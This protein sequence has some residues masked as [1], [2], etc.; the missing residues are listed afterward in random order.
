M[1]GKSRYYSEKSKE[2]K[3]RRSRIRGIAV[4]V[5]ACF[6]VFFAVANIIN[7]VREFSDGENRKLKTVPQLSAES[8]ADGS[9]FEEAFDA[10]SDQFVF[11]DA[12]IGIKSQAELLSG[13][14]KENDTVIGEDGYLFATPETPSASSVSAQLSAVNT[15]AKNNSGLKVSFML[16]P[17]A[18]SVLTD[19]LP[20]AAGLRD[21]MADVDSF[22][23]ALDD[24][25]TFIN[26]GRILSGHKDDYI[27]YRTDHHWTSTGA[28]YVFSE[29]AKNLG[30][31]DTYEPVEHKVTDGFFGT[32]ASSSGVYT[33]ADSVSIYDYKDAPQDYYVNI[34]SGEKMTASM[35]DSEKLHE[36]DKYQVFFGGNHPVVEIGTEA[37]TGKKL[38]IFKDS[39]ANSFVQFLYPYYDKIIMIDPRYYYEDPVQLMKLE[40]ITDVLFLYSANTLFTDSSLV[41]CIGE[42]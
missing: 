15:F 32:Q 23:E 31:D 26:A 37:G 5:L 19:K 25:I 38:M 7:P 42:G 16:A 20:A 29:S 28:R 1:P 33:H 8:F 11:R 35:F 41:D 30:I 12:F 24:S 22:G 4:A 27:Y 36:K 6:A 9:F 39:Y 18:A 2:I 13:D 14:Y 3:I 10:Y 40:G 17:C 21:Q 34:N